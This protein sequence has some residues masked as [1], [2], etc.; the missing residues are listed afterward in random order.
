MHG[1]DNVNDAYDVRLKHW[2][3][4]RLDGREGYTFHRVDICDRPALASVFDA[5][6]DVQAVIN[7]AARAG[8]RQSVEDPWVYVE[9]NTTGCLNLLEECRHRDIGKLMLAST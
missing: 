2:R 6:G 9:T 1:V 3:M 7:L 4:K 8:V 5:A